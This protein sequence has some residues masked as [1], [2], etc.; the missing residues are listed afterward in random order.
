MRCCVHWQWRCERRSRTC[1]GRKAV[2][3]GYN[4]AFIDRL[5]LSQDTL[6][7]VADDI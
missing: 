6:L 3:G 1:C 5:M 2:A 4:K 7:G